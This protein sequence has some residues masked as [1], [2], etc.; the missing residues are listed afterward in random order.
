MCVHSVQCL[1]AKSAFPPP[2]RRSSR[3]FLSEEKRTITLLVPQPNA[4]WVWG[5]EKA[6]FFSPVGSMYQ[7]WFDEVGRVFRMK[8][9]LTVSGWMLFCDM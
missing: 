7:K 6:V 8:G 3:L 4:S 1:E 5:H 9:A 2:C